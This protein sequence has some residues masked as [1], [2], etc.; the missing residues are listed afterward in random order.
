MDI[1]VN[2]NMYKEYESVHVFH[3]YVHLHVCWTQC[4]KKN[5]SDVPMSSLLCLNC[6]AYMCG[7]N[8]F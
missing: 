3:A 1:A 4:R 8:R 7:I 2:M 6:I 5:S